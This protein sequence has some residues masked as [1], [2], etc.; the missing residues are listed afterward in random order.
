MAPPRKIHFRLFLNQ[1]YFL[2]LNNFK[3]FFNVENCNTDPELVASVVKGTMV[4]AKLHIANVMRELALTDQE[5][6]GLIGIHFLLN[7]G[8][9][10]LSIR[11][12]FLALENITDEESRL[13]SHSR[14]AL[15]AELYSICRQKR[16]LEEAGIRFSKIC[17]FVPTIQV[18]KF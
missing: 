14:D 11:T 18:S 6:V 1:K 12:R 13:M 5:F 8:K 4:R 15:F 2:R 16:G 17:N 9:S 3:N 7:D 10:F